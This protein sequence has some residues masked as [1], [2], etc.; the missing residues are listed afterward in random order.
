M[1][2]AI[3]ISNLKKTYGNEFQALKDV[4]LTVKEGEIFGLLGP[5]GAGKSTLINI[6]CGIVKKTSGIVQVFGYS[7]PQ[8]H[9]KIKRLIGVVPQELCAEGFFSVQ[10]VL[11]YQSGFFGIANNQ[12]YINEVL[13]KLNL[14]EKRGEITRYLSGGMKRRMM[15]AKAMV[16]KPKILIL[17][18]PTAGVD[19]ALTESLWK[20]VRELNDNGTTIILTTHNIREAEKICDRICIIDRGQ[21]IQMDETESLIRK[22]GQTQQLEVTFDKFSEGR[23]INFP[24]HI[25]KYG[26]KIKLKVNFHSH[27]LTR[28]LAE[29]GSLGEEIV[30][31]KVHEDRLEDVFRRLIGYA[32]E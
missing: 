12:D 21:V 8:D 18:E 22:L 24:H 23:K 15:V 32:D 1:N 17:D 7:I 11:E 19:I 13:V 2:Q 10:Q 20:A 16:T 5:N 4:N 25:E 31:L 6:L 30:Q 9:L 26:S 28:I 3:E 14:I 29:I 27:E